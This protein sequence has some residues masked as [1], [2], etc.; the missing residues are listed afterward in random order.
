M[1]AELEALLLK[2][3]Q[4]PKDRLLRS[5]LSNYIEPLALSLWTHRDTWLVG[6]EEEMHRILP[7]TSRLI[8]EQ[9]GPCVSVSGTWGPPA[10]PRLLRQNAV[11]RG[12]HHADPL[13]GSIVACLMEELCANTIH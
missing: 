8:L 4:T 10:P 13:H 9:L 11:V 3:Q 5:A 1:Q 7:P 6:R 12:G 2:T